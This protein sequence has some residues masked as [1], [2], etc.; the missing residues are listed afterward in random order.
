MDTSMGLQAFASPVGASRCKCGKGPHPT[1][2]GKCAVGHKLKGFPGDR[3]IAGEKSVLFWKAVAEQQGAIVRQVLQDQ[4]YT[5][6][7]APEAVRQIAGTLA[8]AVL[9]KASAFQRIVELGGP[10]SASNHGRRAFDIW[11]TCSGKVLAAANKLGLQRVPRPAA[12]LADVL[13]AHE[14]VGSLPPVGEA[15]NR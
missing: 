5:E 6:E 1:I 4:G 13:G 10:M 3:L 8:E 9:L 11:D 12:S 15:E 2:V 7:D 14:D